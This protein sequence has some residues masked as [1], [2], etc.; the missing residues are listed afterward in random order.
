[1][2]I[3]TVSLLI[4]SFVVT[5]VS[6][7]PTL[8][9]KPAAKEQEVDRIVVGTSEVVLDA[10][11]KDK[12]GRPVRDLSASDFAV[13][14]DGVPQEIKTF[15]LIT[16]EGAVPDMPNEEATAKA[17]D[18]NRTEPTGAQPPSRSRPTAAA[19]NRIGALALV[20]DRLSPNG[21]NIARRAALNYL[22]GGMR[23]NDIVGV[24]GIDLSLKVLQHFTNN[25]HLVRQAIERGVSDSS[26]S[27]ASNTDQI[28]KLSD[29]QSALQTQVD[30]NAS[31]AGETNDPSSAIGAAAAAQQFAAMSQNI[32]EG[33]DRLEKNQQG[34]ATTDGL[35]AII[36]ELG[37][38]PGRK[39]LV[40]FSEGV[41]LPTTV[42]AHYRSVIGNANRANVSI[43]SVDAAGLRAVSSDS[44]TGGALAK[45]GQARLR[46][47][48]QSRDGFGSMMRDLE[49]NEELMRSDPDGA[50]GDLANAT[51]GVLIANTND[52]GA[53]LVQVTDDLHTYY[54]LTYTPK[55]QNYDGHFRQVSV[56]VNRSGTEV[57]ARKGYYALATTYDSPVMVFEA[58]ALAILGGKSQPNAFAT[59]AAAFN[60]PEA[61]RS[62]L[63]PVIVDAPLRAIN[64]V[65]DLEKKT[66]RTD[67]SVVVLVKDQS[68]RVLRKLSSQYLLTGSLDQLGQAKAGNV[69]F[70]SETE[71]EPGQY[72]V[73]SIVY[74]ATNNQSGVAHGSLLVGEADLAKLRVSSLVVAGRVEKLPPAD[75]QAP[76]P[77]KVGEVLLYPTMGEALH[78][79]AGRGLV[80]LLTV[81]PA[82][83]SSTAPKLS[84]EFERGGQVLG[85]LPVELPPP[86]KNG[87]I[88]Y[89]GTI[90]LD[91]F[92]AGE[93]GLKATVTD[94]TS[95]IIRT[96]NFTVQP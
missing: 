42:M 16:R 31:A 41:V 13:F 24:F 5:V 69:L 37:H 9:Q 36:N 29:Q 77:F 57:Q 45:L 33:F 46:Q 12:K 63:V 11:V 14:E 90:P 86:D 94:G 79:S 38:L 95:T 26:S 10:V 47:A 22:N 85:Q 62:G 30:Q 39:A 4:L 76:N 53:H 52:P 3:W 56:K 64:F 72:T 60:F 82:K 49:R 71:L 93:Y 81:Y 1:M 8:A 67:F 89:T 15:R 51:G 75:Q 92:T 19:S 54:L 27:Y 74:D 65:G 20:F 48:G 83:G 80:L 68:Q 17:N 40:F 23:P 91:A 25:E 43:Y 61:N 35:L 32:L 59:K 58:P 50:L 87:R 96:G 18:A 7:F 78:K 70:Y 28:A 6:P 55:N 21:R 73:E 66:Y 34:Y 88:Q 84:I 2:R 44:Q